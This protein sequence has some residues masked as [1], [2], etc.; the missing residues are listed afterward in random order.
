MN[1]ATDFLLSTCNSKQV[2]SLLLNF[3]DQDVRVIDNIPLGSSLYHISKNYSS[4]GSYPISIKFLN[5]SYI[6]I[7]PSKN[8]LIQNY[9]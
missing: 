6:T 1:Q 7:Y 5:S 8:K 4:Q 2:S 3:G 9:F